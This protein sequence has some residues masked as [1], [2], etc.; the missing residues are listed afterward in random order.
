MRFIKVRNGVTLIESLISIIL[1]SAFLVSILGAYFISRLGTEHA[2]HRLAAMSVIREFIDYELRFGYDGVSDGDGFANPLVK[3]DDANGIADT[4]NVTLDTRGTADT[5]DDLIGTIAPEPYFPYNLEDAAG[6]LLYYPSSGFN[7]K[8]IGFV[9]NWTEDFFGAG[10]GLAS[11][12]RA[13]T[14]VAK[15]N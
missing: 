7:Y 8:I 13:V 1:L 10:P 6:S 4:I 9:I 15:H 2:K 14:Y 3:D 11:S 5:A 12:E